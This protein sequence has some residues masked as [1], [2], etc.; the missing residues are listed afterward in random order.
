MMG[1]LIEAVPISQ[2]DI[3]FVFKKARANIEVPKIIR[4]VYKLDK[5]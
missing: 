3:L 4:T 5:F 1:L 2:A